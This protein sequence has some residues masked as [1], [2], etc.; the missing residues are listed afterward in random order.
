MLFFL[1]LVLTVLRYLRFK[2]HCDGKINAHAKYKKE[3]ERIK[4]SEILIEFI[5]PRKKSASS[6]LNLFYIKIY[7]PGNP[8]HIFLC[9]YLNFQL[10]KIHVCVSYV[11]LGA[12][13]EVWSERSKDETFS[14]STFNE[15]QM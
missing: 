7:I 8:Y 3:Q 11:N 2:L 15:K 14:T 13:C 5:L 9:I 10:K 12:C 6:L 1:N 4:I